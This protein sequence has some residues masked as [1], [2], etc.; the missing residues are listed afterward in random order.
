ML[1]NAVEST[2]II[3]FILFSIFKCYKTDSL[4]ACCSFAVRTNQWKS[5]HAADQ[6][7]YNEFCSAIGSRKSNFPNNTSKDAF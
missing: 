3:Y 7:A 6:S 2:V 4:L 5:I 1:I